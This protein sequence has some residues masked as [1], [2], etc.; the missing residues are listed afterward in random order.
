MSTQ[1]NRPASIVVLRAGA[2]GDTILTLPAIHALRRHVPYRPIVAVGRP[3]YWS[4][5]G[6]LVDRIISADDPALAPLFG[7]TPL[8]VLPSPI[9]DA[10]LLVL[11]RSGATAPRIPGLRTIVAPPLPPPGVHAA[12][13][14]LSSLAP[15]GLDLSPSPAPPGGLL[16]LSPDELAA[17]AALL[18]RADL[19]R[20]I[21][22][23]PGA[24]AAWKRWPAERYAA[25]ATALRAGGQPVALIAGPADDDTIAALL[26]RIDLPVIARLPLRALAAVLAH[27]TLAIGNDSGVTH[28]AAAAGTPT[29]ALFGPTDPASWAPLG[30]VRILRRC[31]TVPTHQGEIRVCPDD[32]CMHALTVEDVLT[33]ALSV[34]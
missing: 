34:E 33:V 32:N 13:H 10:G 26:A 24:G 2:L 3:D 23:H 12:A 18:A 14:L 7:S 22:L 9:A 28:L 4:V 19:H 8:T 16:A 11:W 25:Q 1:P 27:A 15:L 20:P 31:T 21:L 29:I 5:A 17:G 6:P 30:D